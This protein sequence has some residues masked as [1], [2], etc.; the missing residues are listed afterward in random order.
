M[1]LHLA[2]KSALITGA[3]KGIGRAAAERLAIEGCDVVLV[4]RTVADLAAAKAALAIKSKVQI[5]TVA[6]DCRTA[7]RSS[8]W[9]R[10]FRPSIFW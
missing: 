1:D 9:R 10:I 6:A 2:G 8:D 3:S 4:S 7:A 5:E